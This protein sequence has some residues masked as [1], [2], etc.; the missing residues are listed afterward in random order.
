MRW[1]AP[2]TGIAITMALLAAPAPAAVLEQSVDD[3]DPVGPIATYTYRA[4][5]GEANRLKVTGTRGGG[6]T[7]TDP[8][9][10]RM[11][12]KVPA[13]RASRGRIRCRPDRDLAIV[14]VDTVDRDDRVNLAASASA[15]A[16][17]FA[18]DGSLG[19]DLISV[20]TRGPR[21]VEVKGSLG[22]DRIW[23][24]GETDDSSS[25]LSGGPG[26]DRI[27]KRSRRSA[28]NIKGGSGRDRIDSRD[29]VDDRVDCGIGRDLLITRRGE[30]Y[31]RCE[32][33]VRG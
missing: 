23:F 14:R 9:A 13:C 16:S 20:R 22:D 24:S 17:I 21:T 6:I 15:A 29:R 18:V 1:G 8:G 27:R 3:E 32:R 31:E 28:L 33:L 5:L 7:F 30:W 26:N 12:T 25:E 4:G 19:D 11:R 10:R 2:L